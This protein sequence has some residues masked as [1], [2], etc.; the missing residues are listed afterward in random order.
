MDKQEFARRVTQMQGSLYRVAASYL[1]GESDRLDAVAEAIARAWEKRGTLR[2]EAW[3]A[4]W[5]TRILI[6]VCVDI[7]R[8]QKRMTPVENLPEI[9]KESD[10]CTALREAVNH[11]PQKLRT[12]VVLYYMEGYEVLEVA[13]IMGTT[14]GAVCAGLSRAR[15]KLRAMLGEE[16]R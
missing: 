7:Q 2:E 14:K 10:S 11:L 12:M 16:E 13:R 8:K 3:F 5:I 4:T 1:R 15:E 9:P 6:R